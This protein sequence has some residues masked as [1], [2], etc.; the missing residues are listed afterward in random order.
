MSTKKLITRKKKIDRERKLDVWEK[1]T[2]QKR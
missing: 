1:K 2:N